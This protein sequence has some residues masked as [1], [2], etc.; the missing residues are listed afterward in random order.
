MTIAYLRGRL[1]IGMLVAAVV[2]LAAPGAAF[3]AVYNVNTTADHNDT[4]GCNAADCTLR[5]AVAAATS[6]ADTI[7]LPSGNYVLTMSS[8]LLLTADTIVGA[9]AR[10][11]FIDGGLKTRVLRAAGAS[12]A[13]TTS[14][15]SGV[16]IRNGNGG[17]TASSG[18]GGGVLQDGGILELTNV[19]VSGSTASNGGGIAITGGGRSG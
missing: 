4:A 3:A 18:T 5:E 13:V 10:T 6:A 14:R 15:V 2:A 9:G 1:G 16:T 7:N 8:E 11:T 12:A 17:S 19:T